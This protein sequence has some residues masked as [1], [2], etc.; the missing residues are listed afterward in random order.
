MRLVLSPNSPYARKVR[1]ALL[2]KKVPFELVFDQP[3]SSTSRIQELNPLGKVPVLLRDDGKALYDSP[4]IFQ[5][6]EQAWP[7]PRLLP[8][9]PGERIEA[10][11]WEALCDGICDA[12]VT[13]LL[14]RRRAPEK[15]DPSVVERQSGKVEQAL[16]QAEADFAGRTWAVGRAFGLADI[17]LVAAAGYVNLRAPELWQGKYPRLEAHVSRLRERASV[18]ATEPPG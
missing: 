8:V 15:Q 12:A 17:A 9:D 11:R 14:E 4:V 18:A 3:G 2:E 1:I 7:E 10:L 6:V 5:Y 16:A 13:V